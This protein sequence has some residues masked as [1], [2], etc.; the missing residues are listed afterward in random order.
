MFLFLLQ[1]NKNLGVNTIKYFSNNYK[2]T[3]VD[4]LLVET[5]DYLSKTYNQF[6][7]NLLQGSPNSLH[8]PHNSVRC[9]LFGS[10]L[11]LDFISSC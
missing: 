6:A 10:L 9:G 3:L 4:N 8:F 2:N 1:E 11:L 7:Q 5:Q